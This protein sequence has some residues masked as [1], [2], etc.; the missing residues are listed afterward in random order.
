MT[1]RDF[2]RG[3]FRAL[4][5]GAFGSLLYGWGCEPHW[6]DFV[7]RPLPVERLPVAWCGLRVAFLTDLHVG[8][9]A[10]TYLQ[11]VFARV[12]SMQPDLVVYTGDFVDQA[13]YVEHAAVL[14]ERAPLGRLGTFGVLGNHDYG[15]RWRDHHAAANLCQ[16][17]A[18]R[19]ICILRNE[20][21]QLG[22]LQIAGL[23]DLWARRCDPRRTFAQLD[24]VLPSLALV[25]N[26]DAVD[27]PGWERFRGWILAGHTHGGQCRS[28]FLP[29]PLLPVQN[30]R[31]SSGEIGLD[32]GRRLYISRGVGYALRLRFNTRPEVTWF[33]LQRA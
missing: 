3:A 15:V 27:R 19:G 24:P 8:P 2:L 12:R 9:V 29:P 21:V 1:R 6:L 5:A 22:G 14:F 25:H 13:R 7:E 30:R 32:G 31:Y 16:R 4:G 10:D 26:P 33:E 11:H 20:V 28:P 17:L 23:D 18:E